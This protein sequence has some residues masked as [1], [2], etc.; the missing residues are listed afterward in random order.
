MS[1][2]DLINF[3]YIIASVLYSVIGILILLVS[4]WIIEK[5][6][7]ENLW[8]EIVEKHNIA[9]A[10]VCASFMIAV[11]IIISSAIHG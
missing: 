9:L 6:T 5:I 1:L 2:H 4:Y 3:K 8:K 11:A 7:P 10:I